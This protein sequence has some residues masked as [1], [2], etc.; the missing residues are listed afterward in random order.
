MTTRLNFSE[1]FTEIH[2][3]LGSE[4]K[5]QIKKHVEIW[6]RRLI[7]RYKEF[8][9]NFAYCREITAVEQFLSKEVFASCTF[10]TN[11]VQNT[12]LSLV[13]YS[14]AI[15]GLAVETSSIEITAP[16]RKFIHNITAIFFLCLY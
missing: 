5:M 6:K 13:C 16:L 9:E 10:K 7:A 15:Y 14:M 2:V 8:S 12:F 11:N 1:I 3:I 4:V